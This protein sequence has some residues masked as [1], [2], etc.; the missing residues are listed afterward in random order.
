MKFFLYTGGSGMPLEAR[1]TAPLFTIL[2]ILILVCFFIVLIGFLAKKLVQYHKSEKYIQKEQNRKTKKSDIKALAKKTNLTAE[3]QAILWEVCQVIDCNN[4]TYKLKTNSDIIDLFRNAYNLM[5]A[6]NLFN[7]IKMNNFFNCLFKLEM[8][9]AQ[10][11]KV[12]STQ[13]IPVGSI[14]FYIAEDGEQL[15]FTVLSNSRDNFIVEIPDFIYKSP[16]RPQIL[17]RCRF[18]FKNLQGLTHNFVSRVIRYEERDGAYKAVIAHTDQLQ[19]QANRH[20]KREFMNEKCVFSPVSI[21]KKAQN[22]KNDEEKYIFSDKIYMG[23]LSNISAGG[24][25]IQ[26]DLPIKE[27]QYLCVIIPTMGIRERLVGII[28]QSRKLPTGLFAL[29][30]QFTKISITSKNLIY[31]LVYKFEL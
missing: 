23:K 2:L 19:S 12:L 21:N 30:I 1:H 4:I 6:R 15:P 25:C 27:N 22:S 17:V 10:N 29:H 7:D 9:V 26:T 20:F 14:I 3:D 24:C 28:K 5:K 8:M 13:Q 18:T 11:K 31:T 16:R